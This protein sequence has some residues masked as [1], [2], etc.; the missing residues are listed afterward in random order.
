MWPPGCYLHSVLADCRPSG[1]ARA[2]ACCAV[3]PHIHIC[4]ERRPRR[5]RV[6]SQL[7]AVG[8]SGVSAAFLAPLPAVSVSLGVDVHRVLL[9]L[10]LPLH[11]VLALLLGPEHHEGEGH[12]HLS[13]AAETTQTSGLSNAA[14]CPTPRP[15]NSS[16]TV[17]ETVRVTE[18]ILKII[19]QI[20]MDSNNRKHSHIWSYLYFS[21]CY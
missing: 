2:T 16:E 1:T 17:H 8:G 6:Q 21:L 13:R 18:D 15:S 10:P 11:S 3:A 5:R 12:E 7:N 20:L 14:P 19:K 4:S 9:P